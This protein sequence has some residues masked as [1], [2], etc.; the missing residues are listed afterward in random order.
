M[1]THSSILAGIIP[2]KEKLGGLYSLWGRKESDTT[3]TTEHI[4]IPFFFKFFSHA[5]HY[6]VL[7]RVPCAMCMS[8]SISQFIPLPFY[9]GNHKFVFYIC[10]SS[11]FL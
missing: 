7:S 4:H 3:E 10:D 6:R 1:T 11:F 5:A 9:P 2:W 8:I